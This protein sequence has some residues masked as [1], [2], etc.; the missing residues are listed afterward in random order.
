MTA[1]TAAEA[2]RRNRP[3]CAD[4]AGQEERK[5]IMYDTAYDY[6]KPYEV[7]IYEGKRLKE[8]WQFATLEE[9]Q[10]F[11]AQANST[12]TVCSFY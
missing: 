6:S 12:V 4:E 1:E 5:I 2:V 9:A 10:Q 8:V 11:S 7:P 3:T